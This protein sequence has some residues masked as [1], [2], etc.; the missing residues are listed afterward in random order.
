MDTER[1]SQG[2]SE[3]RGSV[4]DSELGSC[5]TQLINA[6]ARGAAQVAAERELTHVDYALLRPFLLV[7]QWTTTQLAGVLPLTPSTI[8]RTVN[9]LVYR[10]LIQRRR[11]V[12]D[13]RVVA[14]TLTEE[15]QTLTQDLHR[16]VR[17]YEEG[18][19]SNVSDEEMAV[20]TSLTSKVMANYAAL[21]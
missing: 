9:K 7:E 2:I 13:R 21:S 6:V 4:S 11:L 3:T 16:R 5:V 17:A 20:L 12:T 8:S 1:E 14:L 18:L 19:C 15:G 10:G